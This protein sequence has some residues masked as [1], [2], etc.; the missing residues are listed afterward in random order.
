MS[1]A[2]CLLLEFIWQLLKVSIVAVTVADRREA[3]KL[4]KGT[5]NTS[6][7][8]WTPKLRERVL[9]I[10]ALYNRLSFDILNL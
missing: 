9:R 1:G 5:G 3:D 8:Y 4:R 7:M 2:G 10:M 6:V